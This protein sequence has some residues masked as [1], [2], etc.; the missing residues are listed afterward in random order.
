MLHHQVEDTGA[1]MVMVDTEDIQ[2]HVHQCITVITV[3]I[4]TVISMHQFYHR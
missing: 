2:H 1:V 4:T 3:T